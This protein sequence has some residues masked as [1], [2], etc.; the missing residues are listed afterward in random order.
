MQIL[1]YVSS[2]LCFMHITCKIINYSTLVINKTKSTIK[3][4]I[5]LLCE[6]QTNWEHIHKR[7]EFRY[8]AYV[9]YLWWPMESVT[10]TITK[11]IWQAKTWA[12][13]GSPLLPC[14]D[15][16]CWKRHFLYVVN[17]AQVP[18]HH[19]FKGIRNRLVLVILNFTMQAWSPFA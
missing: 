3:L 14:C 12:F 17:W 5:F 4:L 10:I 13:Y 1:L 7:K 8:C 15:C 16:R 2:C 9:L 18:W 19:L 6:V 11:K